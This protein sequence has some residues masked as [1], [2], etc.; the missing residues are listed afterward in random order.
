MNKFTKS[1]SVALIHSSAIFDFQR[2]W[3]SLRDL[4]I[5]LLDLD[6]LFHHF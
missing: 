1:D 2:L 6:F 5:F 3:K 4:W